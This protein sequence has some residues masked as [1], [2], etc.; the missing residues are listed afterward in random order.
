MPSTDE[1][2]RFKKFVVV[3]FVT[4]LSVGVSLIEDSLFLSLP[5]PGVGPG[6][7]NVVILAFVSFFNVSDIILIQLLKFLISG[8]FFKG[9]N[10]L[11]LSLSL[12]GTLAA[13]A[14]LLGYL[15]SRR[16]SLSLAGVSCLMASF[17]IAAQL[18]MASFLTGST[19][20]FSFLGISGFFSVVLGFSSG[21]IAN[22]ISQRLKE[23]IS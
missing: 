21:I 18:L 7:N 12:A 8:L 15:L 3:S 5:L 6:L 10:P 14:V 11:S 22:V 17:H 4:A 2:L 20:P 1:A 16:K 13:T 9:F 19:A 23:R